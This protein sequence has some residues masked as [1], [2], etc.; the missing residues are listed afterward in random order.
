M[1]LLHLL[2][3]FADDCFQSKYHVLQK[4]LERTEMDLMQ[5]NMMLTSLDA[6]LDE[7]DVDGESS[8]SVQFMPCPCNIHCSVVIKL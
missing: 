2:D 5:T 7:D 1:S 6:E 3:E 8:K 4:K